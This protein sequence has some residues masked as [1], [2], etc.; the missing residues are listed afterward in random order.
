MTAPMLLAGAPAAPT[1][2]PTASAA[3]AAAP[4]PGSG[5]ADFQSLLA[6]V[7]SPGSDGTGDDPNAVGASA[8]RG[9]L[10]ARHGRPEDGDDPLAAPTPSGDPTASPAAG[11]A[12]LL[13]LPAGLTAQ[14]ATDLALVPGAGTD[15]ILGAAPAAA[16]VPGAPGASV[17]DIPGAT[18]RDGTTPAAVPA[19]DDASPELS[20]QRPPGVAAGWQ[21][22]HNAA[23][24]TGAPPARPVGPGAATAA[25]A[26]PAMPSR[27]SRPDAATRNGA[28]GSSAVPAPT[29]TGPGAQ[30][31]AA[32]DPNATDA[33]RPTHPVPDRSGHPVLPAVPS[34][35]NPATAL[36]GRADPDAASKR[37][38][39]DRET[40]VT[41][42]TAPV[43]TNALPPPPGTGPMPAAQPVLPPQ[44]TAAATPPPDVATQLAGAVRRV[45]TD[46]ATGPGHAH[47]V[48]LRLRPERLGSVAIRL[49][50]DADRA[51]LEVRCAQAD[52]V[53]A[54]QNAVADLRRELTAGG[55]T[56]VGV[57]VRA[58][59][60]GPGFGANTPAGSD[61]SGG[62]RPTTPDRS[63]DTAAISTHAADRSVSAHR[64]ERPRGDGRVDL[65]I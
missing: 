13:P 26:R 32:T 18:E 43:A 52:A 60:G 14:P 2:A 4:E 29:A 12:V 56:D 24:T 47:E 65:L 40:A 5:G 6:T 41:A 59:T 64:L 54:V 10:T 35:P 30:T 1:A 25:A 44:A 51:T 33:V 7:A 9:P 46:H 15:T 55:L 3:T 8:G 31:S 58:D 63:G 49:Q 36:D 45:V 37:S 17:P 27:G 57:T 34:M 53:S 42:A 28:T 23:S 19:A 21:R 11:M 62:Q 48:L 50:V 22:T 16:G 61:G 20:E 38:R 39:P